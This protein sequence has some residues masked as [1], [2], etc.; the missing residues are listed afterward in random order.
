MTDEKA[1]PTGQT[2]SQEKRWYSIR[3]AAE[4]LEISEPTIFRWMKDGILSFYKVGGSTR[5]SKEGLDAVIEKTT[6]LKEAEAVM[7]RCA[8]CG[9][10]G[11]MEGRVQGAGRLYFKPDKTKFWTFEESLV[12]IKARVCPAC[13][14]VQ[15]SADTTT[16][17]K[18]APGA[19]GKKGRRS[20]Q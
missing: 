17:R 18:L 10:S 19:K 14:C 7:G 15:I 4:Y 2:G 5:F 20:E 13:G 1:N 8:A 12:P 11:L 16:L 3:E 9:H 6:G